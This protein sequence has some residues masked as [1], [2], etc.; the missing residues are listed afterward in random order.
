M[1]AHAVGILGLRGS[2]DGEAGVGNRCL[3]FS[4]PPVNSRRR[5][6]FVAGRAWA[7]DYSD[8]T[9]P[10]PFIF[11]TAAPPAMAAALEA[12]LDLFAMS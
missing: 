11:S 6:A 9:R 1:K 10:P 5:G 4:I 8:P 2:A 7:I 12:S 3:S